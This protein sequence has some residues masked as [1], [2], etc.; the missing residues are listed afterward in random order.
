MGLLGDQT[1]ERGSVWVKVQDPPM[2]EG[3]IALDRLGALPGLVFNV[4]IRD[5]R[6]PRGGVRPI[7][8]GTT[9]PS[10]FPVKGV[11]GGRDASRLAVPPGYRYYELFAANACFRTMEEAAAWHYPA[12][13][14]P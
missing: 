12:P 7:D 4:T 8:A 13:A 11:V 14:A 10:T 3:W 9:C 6:G 5:V 1:D 2:A